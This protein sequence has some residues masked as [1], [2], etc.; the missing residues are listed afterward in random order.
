[1]KCPHCGRE[2]ETQHRRAAASRWASMSPEERAAEMSRIRRKGVRNSKRI[3][4]RS[5]YR[6]T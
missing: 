2:I 5:N 1:M 4:R 3:V 6:R